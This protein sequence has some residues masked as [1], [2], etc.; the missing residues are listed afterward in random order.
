MKMLFKIKHLHD[1][2]STVTAWACRNRASAGLV[3]FSGR[4]K[5]R[6]PHD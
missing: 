3:E 1:R 4:A 6:F 2:E 5:P